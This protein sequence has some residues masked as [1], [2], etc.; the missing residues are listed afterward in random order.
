MTEKIAISFLP[1]DACAKIFTIVENFLALR[2]VEHTFGRIFNGYPGEPILR[3]RDDYRTD[4]PS[5]SEVEKFEN[6]R[7]GLNIA[8]IEIDSK[9]LQ[10]YSTNRDADLAYMYELEVLVE[11]VD[12]IAASCYTPTI[13]T[14]RPDLIDRS[15]W[16]P[17]LH[18]LSYIALGHPD[19]SR[20]YKEMIGYWAEAKIFGGVV[21]FDRGTDADKCQEAYLHPNRKTRLFKIPSSEVKAVMAGLSDTH[22][23]L[24]GMD[25]TLPAPLFKPDTSVDGL[26]LKAAQAENIYRKIN[27]ANTVFYRALPQPVLDG[28]VFASHFPNDREERDRKFIEEVQATNRHLIDNPEERRRIEKIQWKQMEEGRKARQEK[29]KGWTVEDF[30]RKR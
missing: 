8:G 5:T 17:P 6:F 26:E 20:N 29:Y 27:L 7:E 16:I 12:A 9:I 24:L 19:E 14:A 18:H 22:Q 25:T 23:T 3:A 13:Y 1:V 2:V 21:A 15:D 28:M 11:I 30:L 4:E 10:R